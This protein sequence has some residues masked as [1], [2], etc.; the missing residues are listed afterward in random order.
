MNPDTPESAP[1]T[2]TR[3]TDED[4]TPRPKPRFISRLRGAANITLFI[5]G[6]LFG[7]GWIVLTAVANTWSEA[8]LQTLTTFIAYTGII[9]FFA[10]VTSFISIIIEN[11]TVP[12]AEEDDA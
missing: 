11:R 5:S 4:P 10:F 7:L 1:E 2:G 12:H 8:R 9:A 6:A 3:D